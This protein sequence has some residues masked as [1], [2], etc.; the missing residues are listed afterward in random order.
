VEALA[1]S[2]EWVGDWGETVQAAAE[3]LGERPRGWRRYHIAREVSLLAG[4]RGSVA[5]GP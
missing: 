5:A 1:S 2:E 4:A 3:M